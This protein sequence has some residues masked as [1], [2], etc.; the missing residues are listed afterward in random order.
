M[1]GGQVSLGV[2]NDRRYWFKGCI[3]EVRFIPE[4]LNSNALERISEK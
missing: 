3:K 4:T 1:T 2:R